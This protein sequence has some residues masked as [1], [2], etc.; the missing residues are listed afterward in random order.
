M[1]TQNIREQ[2]MGAHSEHRDGCHL[3]DRRKT[4]AT[5]DYRKSASTSMLAER[6]ASVNAQCEKLTDALDD[7]VADTA[8]AKRRAEIDLKS[9][10]VSAIES[11]ASAI[12]PIKDVLET[13]LQIHTTDAYAFKD[14]LTLALRK[15]ETALTKHGLTA[16]A[17][18]IGE[19]YDPVL[20]HLADEQS[21]DVVR[22][23]I[24]EVHQKGYLL[25]GRT[26]RPAIV[27]V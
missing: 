10:E 24:V 20:H 26:L 7:A 12:L 6:I 18:A 23:R 16:I 11:V 3:E 22:C 8:Y 13:A 1:M 14:G 21:T 2:E 9:A 15:M 25:H 27:S 4:A 5:T 17:P 19:M